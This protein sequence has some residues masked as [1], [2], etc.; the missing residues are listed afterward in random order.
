M[1]LLFVGVWPD[2]SLL[3]LLLKGK[4]NHSDQN[5]SKGADTTLLVTIPTRAEPISILTYPMSPTLPQARR[6]PLAV[7]F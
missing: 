1:F 3:S 6:L 7:F 4:N 2:P 5:C